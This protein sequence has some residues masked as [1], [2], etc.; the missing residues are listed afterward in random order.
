MKYPE[1]TLIVMA[2]VM[3]L[4]IQ[5]RLL[6]RRKFIIYSYRVLLILQRGPLESRVLRQ[7]LQVSK[8]YFSDL[9]TTIQMMDWVSCKAEAS[10]SSY[11][12]GVYVL[13]SI[14]ETGS[15]SL[16]FGLRDLP[17]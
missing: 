3:I 1:Y 10:S 12:P 16:A 15:Y 17:I 14:T 13:Y 8:T 7:E 4:M 5:W 2:L 6:G 9:I 11:G